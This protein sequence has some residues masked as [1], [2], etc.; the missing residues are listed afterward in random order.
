MNTP[1][2]RPANSSTAPL[3][4]W[5]LAFLLICGFAMSNA[6]PLMQSAGGGSDQV[7]LGKGAAW[8]LAGQQ[9]QPAPVKRSSTSNHSD[10]DPSLSPITGVLPT[11]PLLFLGLL[12]AGL[13]Q[14]FH[15]QISLTP[16][17]AN[18]SP[19]A[20]RAPPLSQSST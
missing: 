6:A 18:C 8:V 9:E 12:L 11:V 17:G 19:C 4:H 14:Y 2:S 5:S 1:V 10:S 3:R 13:R 15:F 16:N 20:P 7:L